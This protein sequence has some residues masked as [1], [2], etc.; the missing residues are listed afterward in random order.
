M[1]LFGKISFD[2]VGFEPVRPDWQIDIEK[3][4]CLGSG[5]TFMLQKGSSENIAE[6]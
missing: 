3:L 1:A 6:C 2:P 4:G 5:D